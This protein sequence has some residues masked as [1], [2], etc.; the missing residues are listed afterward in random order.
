MTAVTDR[1]GFTSNYTY[2]SL[3]RVKTI[4]DNNGF[5]VTRTYDAAGNIVSLKDQNN[6]ITSYT[7]DNLNRVQRSVTPI[8]GLSNSP[9]TTKGIS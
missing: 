6:N 5:T 9:I 8:P 1:N 3:D 2:D 4:T 7:Y